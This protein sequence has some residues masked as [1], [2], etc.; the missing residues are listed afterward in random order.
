MTLL[1]FCKR[2]VLQIEDDTVR[3]ET[4]PA[5][6]AIITVTLRG[7]R[8][9]TLEERLVMVLQQRGITN[10]YLSTGQVVLSESALKQLEA[11]P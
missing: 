2:H 11:L 9:F 7:K 1:E 5:G 4:P 3:L 6:G 8:D 10:R